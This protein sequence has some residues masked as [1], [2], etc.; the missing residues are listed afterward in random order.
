MKFNIDDK[1]VIAREIANVP[2]GTVGTV[3]CVY[4]TDIPSYEVIFFES[5]IDEISIYLEMDELK[6]A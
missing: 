5:S 6:P 3:C 4:G 1:V 2:A